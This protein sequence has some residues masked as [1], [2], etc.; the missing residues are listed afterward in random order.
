MTLEDLDRS[1][2]YTDSGSSFDHPLRLVGCPRGVPVNKTGVPLVGNVDPAAVAANFKKDTSTKSEDKKGK[3]KE[4]LLLG[5]SW[6][7]RM[8]RMSIN[9]ISRIL[10]VGTFVPD[11]W[12]YV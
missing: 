11:V 3:K 7:C 5:T 4:P 1:G 8:G 10:W 12:P 6:D 2:K 9:G